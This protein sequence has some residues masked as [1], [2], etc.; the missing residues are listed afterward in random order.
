MRQLAQ[1]ANEYPLSHVLT[2]GLVKEH[3]YQNLYKLLLTQYL[4]VDNAIIMHVSHVHEDNETVKL[5]E[6]WHGQMF[7][8]RVVDDAIVKQWMNAGE[9]HAQHFHLPDRNDF[10]PR[11]LTVLSTDSY[12][13]DDTV[14]QLIYDDG[15][16]VY[17]RKDNK[18][19]RPKSLIYALVR[20][21]QCSSSPLMD[22]AGQM[23]AMLVQDYLSEYVC[24]DV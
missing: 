14:P 20:S 7:G 4:T 23:F 8:V 1:A 6:R 5:K 17:Y 2:Y 13:K 21:D 10:L 24:G 3:D 16:H 22:V 11:D 15:Y 9:S 12:W 18:Y 19:N